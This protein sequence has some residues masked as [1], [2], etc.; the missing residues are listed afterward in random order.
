MVFGAGGGTS[1]YREIE[2][3]DVILLWGSNARE[4]H[5]IFFHHLLKGVH[6]GAWLA[7]VDP[8]RTS[9]AAWADRWLGLDIGSDVALSNTIAR[10]IIHAGLHNETFIKRATEGFDAY[11]ESVEPFTL[12]RGAQ[13][14]GL[15]A[16]AIREV[17]HRYA[18]ADRAQICWT[19]GITEHHNAVDN[20]LCLINLVMR[21]GLAGKW[22]WVLNPLRSQNYGQGG[23]G[24]GAFPNKAAGFQDIERGEVARGKFEAAWGAPIRGRYG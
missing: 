12:E 6:N 22:R 3:T 17:A 2:E 9:S 14:T 1:S 11:A 4:T 24:M 10:E 19:L 5:P 23:S 8:R 16:E 7:V 20:V 21:W 18:R 13:L 15:P